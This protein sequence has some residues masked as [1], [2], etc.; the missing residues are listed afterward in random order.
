MIYLK[1]RI[2]NR[3]NKATIDAHGGNFLPPNNYLHEENLD[4][5]LEA[6]HFEMFGQPLYP[7][8]SDKVGLYM[9]SIICNHIYQDGNKRT[10][11]EAA[12]LFLRMNGKNISNLVSKSELFNFTMQVASGELSIKEV[13]AWF[14]ENIVEEYL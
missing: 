8:L 5:L 9:H 2:V 12:I 3:I 11:L 7:N 1:N 4:Y 13:Q 10:G 6:V 14:E